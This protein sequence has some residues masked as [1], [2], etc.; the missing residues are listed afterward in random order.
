ME[1]IKDTTHDLLVVSE[2]GIGKRT[3]ISQF[4]KQGRGG[5]GVKAMQITPKTGKLVTA[6]L[7]SETIDQIILTSAKGIVIK[8]PLSSIPKLSRATQGVI[9]MRFSES[10]DHIAAV[11]TLEK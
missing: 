9:L 10:G 6:Q 4:P 11:A 7:V 5:Q 8:L 1:A 2:K 3:A